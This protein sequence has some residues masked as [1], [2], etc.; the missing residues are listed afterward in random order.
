[1]LYPAVEKRE[2]AASAAVTGTIAAAVRR[3]KAFS[4]AGVMG[5]AS[6]LFPDFLCDAAE[7]VL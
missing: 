5:D 6:S 7:P 4:V 1:V 2:I 3:V